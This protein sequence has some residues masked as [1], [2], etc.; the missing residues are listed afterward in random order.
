MNGSIL[1]AVWPAPGEDDPYFF[2]S[3]TNGSALD[4]V[5]AIQRLFPDL[6]T[7]PPLTPLEQREEVLNPQYVRRNQSTRL[8]PRHFRNQLLLLSSAADWKPFQMFLQ[9]WIPELNVERPKV[10][11]LDDETSISVFFTEGRGPKELVWAGDGVQVFLQLLLHLFRLRGT[12]TIVL[13]EPEV[14]L[15][16]DLQRRLL[17]AAM[18][19]TDQAVVATHSS[20]IV[21]EGDPTAIVMV[22]KGRRASVTASDPEV[23]AQLAGGLGSA[24]NLRFARALKADLAIFVEGE[25]T[26]IL[27]ALA[28]TLGASRLSK[29]AGVAVSS[30]RG[31]DNWERLIGFQWVAQDLLKDAMRGYV[32]LDRDYLS[33]QV[34]ESRERRLREAGL[35]RHIW[36]R[37]EIESYLICPEAIARLAGV[38]VLKVGRLIDEELDAL[39]PYIESQLMAARLDEL[40]KTKLHTATIVAHA[41]EELDATWTDLEGKLK[42][43][44]AKKLLSRLNGRLQAEAGTAISIKSLARSLRPE[45]IP[46]E[47]ANVITNLEEILDDLRQQP[48]PARW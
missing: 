20:E 15:H 17:R 7:V 32:I 25:D 5:K 4:N 18:A 45:E 28:N 21:A 11:R 47:M 27:R 23:F 43:A 3:D 38:D 48:R 34:R 46:L 6:G 42:F 2:F 9:E 40:G 44:P 13:D 33:D 41:R 36:R 19:C 24:F 31:V 22:E 10:H 1:T 26:V 16:A 29:E 35:G 39:R 12:S 14:F 37:R 30:L 8:A